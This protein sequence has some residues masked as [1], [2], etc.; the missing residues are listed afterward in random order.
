MAAYASP[1]SG[2]RRVNPRRAAGARRRRASVA[3]PDRPA[4][5]CQDVSEQALIA[6][7]PVENRAAAAR[8]WRRAARG[9]SIDLSPTLRRTDP[10]DP[11][12]A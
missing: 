3:I 10:V 1:T 12:A 2:V 11:R 4:A 6:A 8:T 7:P 9:T 5:T